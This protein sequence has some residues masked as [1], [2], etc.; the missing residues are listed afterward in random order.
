MTNVASPPSQPRPPSAWIIAERLERLFRVFADRARAHGLN[1][2]QWTALRYIAG[3]D[4][5]ARHVSA[6]AAF[7]LTS[8]SSA[9]QTVT[10][11]V[12][13]GLVEK[14]RGED[15]R[16]RTLFVTDLGLRLLE[17]DPLADIVA[18]IQDLPAGHRDLLAEIMDVL[19]DPASV[20]A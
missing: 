13:K 10:A 15:A 18:K 5:E 2:A 7:H 12:R 11:L 16:R 20:A 3:A 4:F 8:P 1:S 17:Q 19:T 9:S 14:R 6:F